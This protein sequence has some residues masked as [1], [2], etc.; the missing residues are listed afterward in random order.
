VFPWLLRIGESMSRLIK[1]LCPVSR[2]DWLSFQ[3]ALGRSSQ[4]AQA[5]W[6]RFQACDFYSD[7][8]YLVQLDKRPQHAFKNAEV[9]Q[10]WISRRDGDHSRDRTDFMRIKNEVVGE[11]FEAVELFPA[12]SRLNDAAN[13]TSLFVFIELNGRR[14]PR[15]PAGP[16]SSRF[17]VVGQ[18]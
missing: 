12:E 2:E 16:E 9:W 4:A 11:E 17:G 5:A 7:D 13:R 8:V 15:F 10:L 3:S 1:V 14:A 18:H 6:E